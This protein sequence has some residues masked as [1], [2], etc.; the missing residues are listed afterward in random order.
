MVKTQI[1]AKIPNMEVLVKINQFKAKIPII[2]CF[3]R[4]YFV[5]EEIQKIWC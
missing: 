4:K 5:K 3:G 2:C 1:V